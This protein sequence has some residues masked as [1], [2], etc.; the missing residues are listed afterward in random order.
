MKR[1]TLG[2]A[3]VFAG[4]VLACCAETC[5]PDAGGL[6]F[7]FKALSAERFSAASGGTDI[8]KGVK[9][10]PA[11]GFVYDSGKS[12]SS[13]GVPPE[14]V[15]KHVTW[16]EEGDEYVVTNGEGLLE[17]CRGDAGVAAHAMSSWETV[18]TLPD[19][20]GGM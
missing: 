2:L 4:G 1:V 19:E 13:C 20:E 12:D 17:V 7:D 14:E 9:P 11:Y 5:A 6:T 18:I 8:A 3:A 15:K 16:K 10:H